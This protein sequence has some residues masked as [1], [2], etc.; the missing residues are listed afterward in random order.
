MALALYGTELLLPPGKTSIPG[1][2]V[3]TAVGGL[4]YGGSGIALRAF[5]L[6]ELAALLRRRRRK[7]APG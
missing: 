4:A 2:L 6:S 3:L 5:D 1:F 7:P